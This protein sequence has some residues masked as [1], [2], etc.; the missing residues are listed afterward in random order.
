M[1]EFGTPQAPKKRSVGRMILTIVILVVSLSFIFSNWESMP[2]Q[3]LW[4]STPSLPMWLWM[5][6]MFVLGVLLGGVV[7]GGIRKMRH[8]DAPEKK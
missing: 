2:V 3:F 4:L 7:R 5:L 6:V 8:K 1:S